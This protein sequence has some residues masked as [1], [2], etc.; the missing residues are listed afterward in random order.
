MPGRSIQGLSFSCSKNLSY[1]GMLAL[2][3]ML[4]RL[5]A[6]TALGNYP[7]SQISV[8][9]QDTCAI[10]EDSS[11]KCWGRNHFG[12][13]GSG[14]SGTIG[15]AANEMGDYLP[16]V[17]LGTGRTAIA[18]ATGSQTN[19][20][21]LDNGMVKCFGNTADGC[22]GQPDTVLA[23]IGVTDSNIGDD[24]FELDDKL[25]AIS[26]G[27]GR[28]ATGVCVGQEFGCA[29]L[30][31][32][33]VKCWGRNS[34]GQ[35]GQGDT[36]TRGETESSMGD[37]LPEIDLGT[38][39]T[40]IQLQCG[41]SFACAILDDV[42]MKCW[43]SNNRNQCGQGHNSNIGDGSNE[44]GDHLPAI[45]F[46]SG[47]TVKSLGVGVGYEHTCVIMDDDTARCWGYGSSS[48]GPC[49]YGDALTRGTTQYPVSGVPAVDLG[50]GRT[51]QQ[52]S[53]SYI[54]TC[55]LL[56]DGSVKCWGYNLTIPLGLR[57]FG[58][59]GTHDESDGGLPSGH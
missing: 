28:T 13:T 46:E 43:G 22:A 52:L 3:W 5:Q 34:N 59:P 54:G 47:R 10:L 36:T 45:V 32:G 48:Y 41:N 55:A 26:L 6:L 21:V 11:L 14:S 9:E 23:T 2:A 19:C 57:R 40:A 38:G 58:R 37:G 33:A 20:I 30:D 24:D 18:V 17:D 56:D 51:A 27:T 39:R 12:I 1:D 4:L 15:D 16:P 8:T 31:N 42:T 35:L 49:G 7:V 50:A 29:L 25:P 53:G 44:M